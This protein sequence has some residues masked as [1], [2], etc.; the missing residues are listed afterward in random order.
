MPC[1]AHR[2]PG[3][4]VFSPVPTIHLTALQVQHGKLLRPARG[5]ILSA[6]ING[7]T[8]TPL[9]QAYFKLNLIQKSSSQES[10]LVDAWVQP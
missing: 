5:H 2:P 8:E 4:Q 9:P 10:F 1:P 7:Y 6:I 3:W